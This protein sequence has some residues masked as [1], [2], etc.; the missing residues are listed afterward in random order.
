[1]TSPP[2]RGSM[3]SKISSGRAWYPIKA[4]RYSSYHWALALDPTWPGT[5]TRRVLC[6][7]TASADE[8]LEKVRP[9]RVALGR[10]TA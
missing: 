8:I 9:G 3:S 2:W 7:V 5:A 6:S 1:M 10:S 4:S